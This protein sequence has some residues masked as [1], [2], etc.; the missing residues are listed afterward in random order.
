M[1]RQFYDNGVVKRQQLSYDPQGRLVQVLQAL[2]DNEWRV[3]ETSTYD[4]AG[5]VTERRQYADDGTAKHIDVNHYDAN[6]RLIDQLAYGIPQGGLD[7]QV[8]EEGNPLPDNGFE[9]LSLLTTTTYQQAGN[10]AIGYDSADRLRGYRYQVLRNEQGSGASSPDGY[11]HTYRTT[12]QGADSYLTSTVTGTSTNSNYKTSNSTS[13]YDVWGQ[14]ESV[15]ERTPGTGV[16]DR[17]RIF[18]LDQAGNILRRTEGQSD[19]AKH[20]DGDVWLR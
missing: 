14:L 8:D 20:L 10:T 13:T 4:A 2:P 3:L 19:Q 9:G 5:R 6:G 1:F 7:P 16:E 12:Y 17:V 18:S 11:T 15:R